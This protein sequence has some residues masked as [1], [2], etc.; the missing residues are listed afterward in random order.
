MPTRRAVLGRLAAP[1][2]WPL[3]APV[4]LA[5]SPVLASAGVQRAL[6]ALADRSEPGR[7]PEEIAADESYWFPIQQAFTPDR[8]LI[9][10]NFGGVSAAP[11]VVQDAMKRHLDLSNTAPA[12]AMWRV[13]EPRRE[14]VRGQLAGLFGCSADEIAITRNAS[15]SLQILQCGF[16]LA[17]GDELL[18][19]DQDYPRMLA[20]WRQRQRRE[21]VVLRTFPL[22]VPAEDPAEIV[23]RFEAQITPR[24]RLIL[25]SH[26]INLTGQILPVRDLVALGRKRGIPVLVDG[27]HTFAH[28]PFTVTDLGCEYFATSLHKWLFAPHGT[29]FLYVRRERIRG[30][31]PL[32]AADESLDGDI[33]KFEEIGTH[34]AANA[35]AISEAV[36][37]HLGV[38]PERKAA[39]LRYL[40]DTWARRLMRNDRVRLLTSLRPESSCGIGTFGVEGVAPDRLASHLW[41]RHRILTTAIQHADVQGVRVTPGLSTTLEE[42]ERF[43]EA[44]EGVIRAGLPAA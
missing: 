20:T 25:V 18:T 19:S 23:R 15:E 41:D 22:P 39:R 32:T 2:A 14:T 29:G 38:G 9:N 44:V 24:T 31:W 10:L 43:C 7:S 13:L 27:A 21:K 28:L 37:F 12:W 33:R 26:M 40:R 17:P 35:L 8:S 36:T 16:D 5:A 42:V 4:A 11:L 1:A 30:L 34:P 6:A 3:L